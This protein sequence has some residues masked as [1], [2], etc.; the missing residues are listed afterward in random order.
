MTP[1]RNGTGGPQEKPQAFY[2]L[3]KELYPGN[4][5]PTLTHYFFKL[6]ADKGLL[7]AVCV[8]A[9]FPSHARWR[10]FWRRGVS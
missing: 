9:G 7:Q 1:F 2:T 6:L 3:A 8:A 4:F 5:R 10:V